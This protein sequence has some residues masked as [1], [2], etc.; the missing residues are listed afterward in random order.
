VC[1]RYPL[2]SR[3]ARS[4]SKFGTLRP[5]PAPLPHSLHLQ[6]GVVPPSRGCPCGSSM[7]SRIKA[8]ACSVERTKLPRRPRMRIGGSMAKSVMQMPCAFSCALHGTYPRLPTTPLLLASI[9]R[10]HVDDSPR[11]C[12]WTTWTTYSA[13]M[14]SVSMPLGHDVSAI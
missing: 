13:V 4:Q 2:A 7:C 5:R 8:A 12:C 1:L 10:R 6:A 9:A 14:P 11:Q 3:T